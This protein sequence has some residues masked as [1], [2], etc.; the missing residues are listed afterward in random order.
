MVLSWPLTALHITC[1][2]FDKQFISY[3]SRYV[4]QQRTVKDPPTFVKPVGGTVEHDPFLTCRCHRNC[5][6]LQ[7]VFVEDV[8]VHHNDHAGAGTRP[9]HR[10]KTEPPRHLQL[11]VTAE[12]LENKIKNKLCENVSYSSNSPV[13][14]IKDTESL[15][16]AHLILEH[17]QPVVA[18]VPCV[19]TQQ[20]VLEVGGDREGMAVELSLAKERNKSR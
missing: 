8:V 20:D 3:F 7:R 18:V 19:V 14:H 6:R 10:L 2:N 12:L 9:T 11:V 15:L 4:D 1:L 17:V 5:L 13:G 16:S